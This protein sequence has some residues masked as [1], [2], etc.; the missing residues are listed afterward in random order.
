MDIWL[1]ILWICLLT[2]ASICVG[3]LVGVG[4]KNKALGVAA[5]LSLY[6]LLFTLERIIIQL[7]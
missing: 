7:K 1:E 4:T 6:M 5:W 3:V 2:G